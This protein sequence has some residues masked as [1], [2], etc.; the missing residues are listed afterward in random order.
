MYVCMFVCMHACI[1]V[2]KHICMHVCIYKCTL[3]H[4]LTCHDPIFQAHL[5]GLNAP[6]HHTLSSIEAVLKGKC[7][8]NKT[9]KRIF[10]VFPQ[11]C[12]SCSV[13]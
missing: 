13:V 3:T 7:F 2:F 8:A 5:K 4:L 12:R 9:Q 6:L 11:Q 1:Y 10:I